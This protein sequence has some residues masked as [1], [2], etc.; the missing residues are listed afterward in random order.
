[1][2]RAAWDGSKDRKRRDIARITADWTKNMPGNCA[3]RKLKKLK[4]R[5]SKRYFH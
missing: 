2:V 4:K 3:T 1:M 5:K